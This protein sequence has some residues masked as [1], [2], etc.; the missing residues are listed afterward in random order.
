M[1]LPIYIKELLFE[2]NIV[3][4]PNIGSF[5]NAYQSATVDLDKYSFAP[6]L[7]KIVF[8][9][10]I[11]ND[12]G[13]LINYIARKENISN[14]ESEDFII[15]VVNKIKTDLNKNIPVH[16]N[17]FGTLRKGIDGKY[18]FIDNSE[19]NYLNNSFGLSKFSFKT[20]KKESEIKPIMEPK[21]EPKVETENNAKIEV[22][23]EFSSKDNAKI[24][25]IEKIQIVNKTK[26]R[27]ILNHLLIILFAL[28][29]LLIIILN[30]YY[31]YLKN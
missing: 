12:D 1:N 6:P 14:L 31:K 7:K 29:T 18:F 22:E 4:L 24:E 8:N 20:N 23:T 27:N 21:V 15:T 3:T 19:E 9:P 25:S 17:N 26:K 5:I 28:T 11:E 13:L 2:H 16:L 10:S 30:F